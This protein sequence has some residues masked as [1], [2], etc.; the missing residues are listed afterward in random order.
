MSFGDGISLRHSGSGKRIE[1]H[2]GPPWDFYV[3]LLLPS[4]KAPGFLG[5]N[6]VEDF[7]QYSFPDVIHSLSIERIDDTSFLLH[8]SDGR[9]EYRV[10]LFLEKDRVI[11]ENED[12]SQLEW[13][14]TIDQLLRDSRKQDRLC[15][16]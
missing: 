12:N 5:G 6:R 13:G 7:H 8:C 9:S 4:K 1:F 14:N 2:V 3:M 11:L 16:Y 15:C 10:K